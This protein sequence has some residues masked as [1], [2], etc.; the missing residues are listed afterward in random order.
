MISTPI[1]IADVG[2]WLP[3]SR[4]PADLLA[5]LLA[6]RSRA[7]HPVDRP[8]RTS[9]ISAGAWR[10]MSRLTRMA[11][12]TAMP[13]IE[14]V[15]HRAQL[16]LVWGTRVGEIVPTA[17]FLERLFLEGPERAS[18]LAFQNSVYNAPAGHLSMG[19][20]LRGATETVSAGG[21][22]GLAALLRGADMIRLGLASSV[23]VIAGD[24][25]TPTRT[26]AYHAV[27]R[28]GD[29]TDLVAA[30]L[31]TSHPHDT[32]LAVGLGHP[33][34]AS[35]WFCRTQALAMEP[36]YPARKGIA[37]EPTL[38]CNAASGL[39]AVVAACIEG[40]VV[41]DQDGPFR[42]H[43]RVEFPHPSPPVAVSATLD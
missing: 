19:A 10:R 34:A 41:V 31:L 37:T 26:A 21:A 38:G 5:D 30:V 3:G 22:T 43:A 9:T 4:A 20:K 42:L 40:G 24:D 6:G 39:A 15:S 1:Y 23:L 25:R 2:L 14:A 12:A 36:P 17:R 35:R 28:R 16:G 33:D 18:P 27:G 8:T 32:R 13:M 11:I 29:P 7:E